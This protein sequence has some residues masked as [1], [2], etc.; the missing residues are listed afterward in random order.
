MLNYFFDGMLIFLWNKQFHATVMGGTP[1]G[2]IG[3][4]TGLLVI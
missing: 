4:R 3:T 1:K 2:L